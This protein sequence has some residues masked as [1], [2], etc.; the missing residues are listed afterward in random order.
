MYVEYNPN[1]KGRRAG[2]CVVR[3]LSKILSKTWEEVYIELCLFAYKKA[4]MPT[5][6]HVW[7][8]YLEEHGYKRVIL[9]DTCPDCYTVEQFCKDHRQGYY[10][11]ATGSHAVA[12][13][14]GF[15][16]DAWDSGQE[17]VIYYF[18]RKNAK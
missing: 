8:A 2:D 12:E 17:V 7:S 9:P 13:I 18:E 10:L 16:F 14:D 6:N 1:P 11:L 5:A 3:A 4:D 15:Y